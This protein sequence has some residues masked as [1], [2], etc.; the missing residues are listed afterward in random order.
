MDEKKNLSRYSTAF[1]FDPDLCIELK[2]MQEFKELNYVPK[3]N[4]KTYKEHIL[5]KFSDTYSDFKRKI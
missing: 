2:S 4:S 5:N 3:Y 1:F